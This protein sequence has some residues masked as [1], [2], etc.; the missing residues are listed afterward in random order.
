MGTWIAISDCRLRSRKL[1]T[2]A[3]LVGVVGCHAGSGP[4][5]PKVPAVAQIAVVSGG[6]Q[7]DTADAT[8][9]A[10]LV[11]RVT[12]E[13]G[14]PVSEQEVVWTVI[15]GSGSVTPDTAVT[16]PSGEAQA[17]WTLG[18][19]AGAD[20]VRASVAGL[21]VT[22]SATAVAGAPDSLLKVSGDGQSA[23]VGTTLPDSLV[24]RVAD[25]HGNPISGQEVASSVIAGGGSLKPDDVV[26]DALGEAHA[27]WTLGTAPGADTVRVSV[28]GVS[29]TFAAMAAVGA[30]DSLLKVGGDAQSAV[31]GTTLP[32]SLE[33]RLC[34]RYGNPLGGRVVVWSV[35][36]GSGSVTADS[37]ATDVAG[38]AR[39]AWTLGTTAGA[40]TVR[41]SAA[42]FSV[43]FSAT[44]VPGAPH[45]L[46]KVA[47]DRQSATAGVALPDSLVV[48]LVDQNGNPVVGQQVAWSVTAGGGSV[49]QATTATNAAGQARTAWNLGPKVGADTVRASAAGMSVTFSAMAVVGAPDSLLKVSGDGQS[50]TVG[51]TLP[52]SLVV[53]LVDRNGNPID[54]QQVTWSV[55]AGGGSVTPTTAATDGAGRARAAW[56]LGTTAGADTVRASAAGLSVTFSA[57]AVASV[58]DSLLKISGDGQSATIGVTLPDSIVVRVVDQN[59]SPMAGQQVVWSVTGGGGSVTPGAVTTDRYGKARAVWTLG[60]APGTNEV[61]ASIAG[62]SAVFTAVAE[63]TVGPGPVAYVANS[64]SGTVSVIDVASGTVAYTMGMG[65]TQLGGLALTPDGKAAWAT[66][67]DYNSVSVIDLAMGTVTH[68]FSL[69]SFG[70]PQ[71]VAFTPG[72]KT[73]FVVDGGVQVLDVASRSVTAK[74]VDNYVPRQVAVR[75][76][77]D[78]AYVTLEGS[79]AVSVLDVASRKETNRIPVGAWPEWVAF[80]PDGTKAYVTNGMDSTVSVIDAASETVTNTIQVGRFPEGIAF[81]PDGKTAYVAAGGTVWLV[82]VATAGVT[83]TLNLRYASA[84]YGLAFTPDGKTLYVTDTENNAVYVVDVASGKVTNTIRVGRTPT[85]VVI[86]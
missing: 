61:Q 11:V 76:Q 53:R 78:V 39:T 71:G 50:V 38:R 31:V 44:A 13:H 52:D 85:V 34:D 73:A 42:G 49:T 16:D 28:A 75:P 60:S 77:G 40:D 36:A 35:T 83:G 37:V 8:L 26:T 23:T 45:A 58:P 32:D 18:A 59:G 79:N 72:G 57:L 7:S 66:D 20:T 82:D 33:V 24:V 55:T 41:A 21:S 30:P 29:V 68:R 54:G 48:G 3:V 80:T 2:L 14:D 63:P 17:V 12:D 67:I 1:L 19:A 43:I 70:V 51:R 22:F 6:N 81:T 10:S 86:H 62:L 5:G 25:A 69:G 4:A 9:P 65:N 84:T 74:I 64:G 15:A 27:A 47:G 56:T 46:L